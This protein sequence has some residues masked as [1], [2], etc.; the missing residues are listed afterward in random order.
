MLP[1]SNKLKE[2]EKIVGQRTICLDLP[3]PIL[4]RVRTILL[5]G[6]PHLEKDWHA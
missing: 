2:K 1:W 5:F 6:Q 4:Q 3:H